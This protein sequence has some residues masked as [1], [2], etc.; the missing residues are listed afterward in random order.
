[1]K[2]YSRENERSQ[3]KIVELERRRSTC[4][5]GLAALEACWTQVHTIGHDDYVV[6]A[7]AVQLV[8]TIRSVVHSDSLPPVD[9][10]TQGNDFSLL[11]L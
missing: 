2:H 10:E 6:S 8:D 5:A 4:E 1:M 9:V 11:A 3:A 7:N